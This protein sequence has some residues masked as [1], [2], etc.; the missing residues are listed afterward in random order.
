MKPIN[1]LDGFSGYGGFH[2]ALKNAGYEFNKCYFSEID[3]YAIANYRYNFPESIYAGSITDIPTNGIIEGLDLFT[4]GWPCQDNSSNGKRQGQRH[5]TRSGLLYAAAKVISKY[6]PRIFVAENVEGLYT[7]NKGIDIVESFR[8]LTY[9]YK[10]CP[11]YDIEMQFLDTRF[12]WLQSRPRLYFVGYH[13]GGDYSKVFPITGSSRPDNKREIREY[14]AKG[15]V[16]AFDLRCTYEERREV[17]N[18]LYIRNITPVEEERIQG[19]PDNW[20]KLGN[21]EGVIKEIPESQRYFLTGNGV[22]IPV[23][24]NILQKLKINFS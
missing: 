15:I 2:L 19:L 13:R 20:T 23:V 14:A 11:Q 21:F 6:K 9:L 1:Y 24:Q 16:S 22:S 8:V 10:N 18:S 4:F 17:A 5:G 7:V 12:F 3:K